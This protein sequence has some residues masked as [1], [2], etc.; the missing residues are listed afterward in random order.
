M[1]EARWNSEVR[2]HGTMVATLS[3]VAAGF[4]STNPEQAGNI[5]RWVNRHTKLLAETFPREAFGLGLMLAL[6]PQD[7]QIWADRWLV[8]DGLAFL[9]DNS[10]S[11]LMAGF[12]EK[13]AD[14]Y[15]ALEK[16]ILDLISRDY[17]SV[18][19]IDDLSKIPECYST[20]AAFCVAKKLGEVNS[21]L[22][23][24]AVLR[25]KDAGVKQM[26]ELFLQ[27]GDTREMANAL[28]DRV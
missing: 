17:S 23:E 16:V 5:W 14:G 21:G 7:Q 3:N 19:S 20:L 9:A 22:G 1:N 2:Y 4:E 15:T 28:L 6:W 27:I 13:D 8:G 12:R 24:F 18:V 11:D 25:L 10:V 26:L